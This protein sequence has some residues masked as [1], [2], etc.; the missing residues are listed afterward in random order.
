VSKQESSASESVQNCVNRLRKLDCSAVSDALDALN[1]SGVVTG[2]TQQSGSGRI[3]GRVVTVKLGTGVPPPGPVR[4]LG[5]LAVESAGPLDVI[6]VEQRTGLDAGSWGGLLSL[7]AKMRGVVGVVVDGPVRDIDEAIG[8]QFPI[9]ARSAT[10]FTARGRI[11]EKGTNV[12]VQ[13]GPITVSPPAYVLA[14]R[15]AVIFIA[16]KHI[17]GVLD[18]AEEIAAR[19]A[20]MAKALVEGVPISA[21]MSGNYEHMLKST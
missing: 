5:T 21:V 1:L 2:L 12:E 6:V 15:G 7:G 19:E 14:D 3:A 16:A 18:K 4:H 10:V 20:A 13:I 11:V 9:F 17:A 8:Y